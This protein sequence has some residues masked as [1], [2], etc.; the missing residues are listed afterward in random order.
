MS[1]GD[2]RSTGRD[3]VRGEEPGPRIPAQHRG[4]CRC[5]H[6]GDVHEHFRAGSD[7]AECRCGRYRAGTGL[8]EQLLLALRR[9]R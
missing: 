8:A 9:G 3:D 2:G 5:G 1:G 7:C 6:P 4:P